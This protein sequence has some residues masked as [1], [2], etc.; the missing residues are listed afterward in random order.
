M[1]ISHVQQGTDEWFA[2]RAG[3]VTASNFDKIITSTGAQTASATRAAYLYQLAGERITGMPEQGFTTPWMDRGK[4]LEAEARLFFEQ[5]MGVFV[6]EIGMIYSNES[7]EI[8]C[9]PDGVLPETK[10]GLEIK[11]PKLSTH[12]GYLDKGQLPTAY[13]QQVQ[14]SMMVSGLQAWWF[15]SYYPGMPPLVIKVAR[16]DGYI[17]TLFSAVRHFN[18]Q[19]NALVDRLKEKDV[20]PKQYPHGHNKE[21]QHEGYF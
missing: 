18:D 12:V 17:A 8:S 10:E 11:C 14:G 13:K 7:R 21:A 4:E 20:E 16:D 5:E 1:I 19:V 6:S 3:K 15:M 2:E 9:S